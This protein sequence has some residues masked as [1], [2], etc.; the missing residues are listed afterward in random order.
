MFGVAANKRLYDKHRILSLAVHPGVIE[1]ELARYA[2][3]E[4]VAVVQ[5]WKKSRKLYIKTL[6]AG[7][8]TTLVAATDP[9]LGMPRTESKDGQETMGRT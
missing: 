9:R 5:E 2:A 1:T 8:A 3:P 7:A 4:S 6:G